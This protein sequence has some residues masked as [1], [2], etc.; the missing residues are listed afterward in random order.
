[1]V[2]AVFPNAPEMGSVISS[3][4]LSALLPVTIVSLTECHC[5]LGGGATNISSKTVFVKWGTSPRNSQRPMSGVVIRWAGK[6]RTV[7][8]HF[9]L[10]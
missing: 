1:M 10:L 6:V 9:H 7:H 2:L 3:G 4:G 8:F 5:F